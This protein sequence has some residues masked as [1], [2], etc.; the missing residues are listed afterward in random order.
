M[1]PAIVCPTVNHAVMED[2]GGTSKWGESE[3]S[4]E[5]IKAP[6][7]AWEEPVRLSPD[8]SL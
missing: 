5:C 2:G 1:C 7:P 6:C 8:L 4:V 3:G